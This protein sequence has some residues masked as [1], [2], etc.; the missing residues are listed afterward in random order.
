MWNGLSGAKARKDLLTRFTVS[1]RVRNVCKLGMTAFCHFGTPK[2][3][4]FW[5]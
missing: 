5:I 4:V 2:G 3:T 1:F